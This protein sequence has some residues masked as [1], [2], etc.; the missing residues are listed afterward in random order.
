MDNY[1]NIFNNYYN[2]FDKDAPMINYKYLHTFRVVNY[3]KEVAKSLNLTKEKI[4]KA[5]ICALFHDIG[6]FKQATLY[7]DFEDTKEYDHGDEGASIIK[8]LGINDEEIINS[9]K[10]HNKY[11]IPKTIS[12]DAYLY[13]QIVRD[14]DKLDILSTQYETITES[15][16]ISDRVYKALIKEE[17]LKNSEAKNSN[18]RLLKCLAYIY[19]LNFKKSFE[20]LKEE[21]IINKKI[22]NLISINN[23][24][25]LLEIKDVLNNYIKGRC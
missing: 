18:E 7:H 4:E 23:D 5:M 3:A 17:L 8:E 16:K 20:M 24:S 22:D 15:E 25:R 2:L 9:T 11:E 1:I 6:R 19:D 14:A 13:C 12:K 10:Y 21:D